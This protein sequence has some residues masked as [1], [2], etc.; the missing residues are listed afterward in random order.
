MK[1]NRKLQ[2]ILILLAVLA[3][4][5]PMS[6]CA[7]EKKPRVKR[8]DATDE[9]VAEE[10]SKDVVV[11]QN[12]TNPTNPANS[13]T[14]STSPQNSPNSSST[15]TPA[16]VFEG[17]WDVDNNGQFGNWN[18][19]YASKNADRLEGKITDGS[20]S[21]IGNYT[22]FPNK[23]VE[24]N[25]GNTSLIVPYKISNGGNQIE[26]S[27]GTTK[28]ILTK[29]KSNTTI[30]NDGNI[31]GSKGWS[32]VTNA[33]DILNFTSVKKSSAGW[34]GAYARGTDY[35]TFSMTPG[36]IT[37]KSQQNGSVDTYSYKLRNNSVLDL[38]DSNG[39]TESF[40]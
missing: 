28:V 10:P 1:Y 29:G 34:T 7:G 15:K 14:T 16:N 3:I 8:S 36:K 39:N 6:G 40:N 20:S 12:N 27:D 4:L 5:I 2:N 22:V 13:S 11:V 32:N 35:G 33:N 25:F 21:V 31:L 26:V 30:Q 19:S 9:T 37:L 23:T 18:F 38:T 17:T 24:M